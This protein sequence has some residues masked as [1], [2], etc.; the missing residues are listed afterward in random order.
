M[1]INISTDQ[2]YLSLHQKEYFF[3]RNTVEKELGPAL[4]TLARTHDFSDIIVLNWPGGFTNLRVGALCLNMLNTLFQKKFFLYSID[5]ISLYSLL[6]KKKFLPWRWLVYIG[7]KKNI[8]DYDFLE[9][10]YQQ[11]P[12]DNIL[13]TEMGKE[14]FLDLVYDPNYFWKP[15]LAITGTG[16]NLHVSWQGETITITKSELMLT[17]E[18]YI[19]AN[20]FIQPILGKQWQKNNTTS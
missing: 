16:D 10:S 13:N 9:N 7:Q 18:H 15:T 2:I 8:W 3:D 6:V 12:K 14:Y 20:Y 1:F 11:W 5:K 19:S 4:V 17:P